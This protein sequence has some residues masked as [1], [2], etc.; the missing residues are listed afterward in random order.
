MIINMIVV[1]SNCYP[2]Q[3]QICKACHRMRSGDIHLSSYFHHLCIPQLQ[4]V[5]QTELSSYFAVIYSITQNV[6]IFS[7][8]YIVG[9]YL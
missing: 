8:E 5:G 3:Y 6:V 4:H 2:I 9:G 7:K 1:S